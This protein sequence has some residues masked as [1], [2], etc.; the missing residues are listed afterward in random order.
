MPRNFAPPQQVPTISLQHDHIHVLDPCHAAIAK[1]LVSNFICLLPH[2]RLFH[3]PITVSF[4]LISFS[5]SHVTTSIF[6]LQRF[7]SD[8]IVEF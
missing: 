8:S 2:E 4:T 5:S 3:V 7:S 1:D 6:N